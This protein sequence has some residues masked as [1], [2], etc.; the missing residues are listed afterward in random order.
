MAR[1]ALAQRLG[2]G[3]LWIRV[4]SWMRDCGLSLRL[5]DCWFSRLGWRICVSPSTLRLPPYLSRPT[6]TTLPPPPCITTP[7]HHPTYLTLHHHPAPSPCTTTLH[8]QPASPPCTIQFLTPSHNSADEMCPLQQGQRVA[9]QMWFA[10]EGMDP[11]WAFLQ[12][13]AFQEQFG[14]GGPDHAAPPTQ[15]A[16]PK[17][18]AFASAKPWAWR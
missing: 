3:T 6:S 8:H 18:A 10:C 16:P 5:V 7:H 17:T 9:I 4:G 2:S 11:G 15:A 13:I 14:Y 12:R 1:H